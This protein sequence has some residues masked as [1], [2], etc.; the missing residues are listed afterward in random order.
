MT[1]YSNRDLAT[2][3]T[4][5]DDPLGANGPTLIREIHIREI[6]TAINLVRHAAGLTDYAWTNT[7][8]A[9]VS[10]VKAWDVTEMRNVLGDARSRLLLPPVIPTYAQLIM[11]H[12]VDFQELRDGMK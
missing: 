7:I 12:A 2:L 6:R 4:F 3:V 1:A 9:G 11:I 5:T 8:T 10:Y